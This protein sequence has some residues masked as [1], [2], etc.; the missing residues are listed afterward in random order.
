MVV[1]VTWV[2][3]VEVMLRCDVLHCDD[4]VLSW[5]RMWCWVS[6]DRRSGSRC[7]CLPRGKWMDQ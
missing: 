2:N 1:V 7:R 5:W 3:E 6:M 4:Q